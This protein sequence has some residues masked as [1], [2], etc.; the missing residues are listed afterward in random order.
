M[1]RETQIL[2]PSPHYMLSV[3]RNIFGAVMLLALDSSVGDV[4]MGE[5][6]LLTWSG[7]IERKKD[8]KILQ[9]GGIIVYMS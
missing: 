2:T 7:V 4:I 3:L 6:T 5:V 9:K 1:T 8:L